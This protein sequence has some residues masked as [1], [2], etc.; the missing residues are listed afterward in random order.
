[1]G[2]ETSLHVDSEPVLVFNTLTQKYAILP[3]S[4]D[5]ELVQMRC[6]ANYAVFGS[7]NIESALALMKDYI[8]TND[9]TEKLINGFPKKVYVC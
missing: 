7:G 8:E 4:R 1:M 9:I 5:F 6:G 2:N 3:S